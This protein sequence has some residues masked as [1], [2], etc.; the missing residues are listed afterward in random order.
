MNDNGSIDTRTVGLPGAVPEIDAYAEAHSDSA[1][2][3]VKE[4]HD[5]TTENTDD[6]RMLSGALQGAVLRLL[7]LSVG[8]KRVLEIGMF[9]GY[10]ALSVAEVLPDD[11]QLITLDIDEE[12][13]SIARSYFDRSEHGSKITIVIGDALETIPA[14]D[15]PF[16]MVY[17]DA[18]KVNYPNYYDAVVP[19]VS[20][21]GL[22]VADNVLWS[23]TVLN[24][25]DEESLVLARFNEKV[26]ADSRVSNVLLP[27]R[28]G[29]MV[30][31]KI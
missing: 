7:A 8:A 20:S 10:S 19:L 17:I 16:D 9:T 23:G 18:D 25:E 3:L 1:S 27:I 4:I 26:H 12:R 22:I 31:R 6:H 21:G 29:L 13:E 5:W 14:L 24:P 15:G 28:D 11:G 2:D 30:A